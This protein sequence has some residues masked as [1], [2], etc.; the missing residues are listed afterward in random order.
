MPEF[1]SSGS[2]NRR[3]ERILRIEEFRN[4]HELWCLED[5]GLLKFLD[6]RVL[7]L[8]DSASTGFS[9]DRRKFLGQSGGFLSSQNLRDL[10]ASRLNTTGAGC[11]RRACRC[12]WVLQVRCRA[13]RSASLITRCSPCRLTARRYGDAA[14]AGSRWPIVG[15]TS[16]YTP[17][18]ARCA[19]IA[20]P[21]TAGSTLCART[22]AP[23]TGRCCSPG[24]GPCRGRWLPREGSGHR[25][26]RRRVCSTSAR[27]RPSS[28]SG[29]P[30]PRPSSHRDTGDPNGERRPREE[31][32]S[33]DRVASASR[34]MIPRN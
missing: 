34:A 8:G 11:A 18:S 1:E 10:S 26:F 13:C 7:D 6:L 28:A 3:I 17:R 23:S 5:P 12:C 19:P 30:D 24:R 9:I 22:Y 20:R 33:S 14:P 27:S 15:T 31:S 21:P 25:H 29:C 4:Q 16:T 32:V 2:R